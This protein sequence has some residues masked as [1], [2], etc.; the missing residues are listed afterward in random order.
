MGSSRPGDQ[1]LGNHGLETKQRPL[2]SLK[3]ILG[4]NQHNFKSLFLLNFW[5]QLN[6]SLPCPTAAPAGTRGCPWV[7]EGL[8]GVGA[9]PSLDS[10]LWGLKTAGDSGQQAALSFCCVGAPRPGPPACGP[11]PNLSV[12][13]PSLVAGALK[14]RVREWD[15]DSR[16][17]MS[18]LWVTEQP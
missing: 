8:C 15:L 5:D 17:G 4:C 18:L 14:G 11:P 7:C 16:P 9:Q 3:T 10:W 2:V 12:A 6:K 1:K 13:S